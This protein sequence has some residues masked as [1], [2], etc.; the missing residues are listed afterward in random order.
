MANEI[1]AIGV[2]IFAVFVT[3]YF[4]SKNL[5][6]T[7]IKDIKEEAAEKAIMSE[8]LTEIGTDVKD[9]KY[10]ISS[11]KIKVEEL[12]KKVALVEQSTKSAHKRLDEMEVHFNAKQIE[13]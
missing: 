8:K 4:A 13:K 3:A 12:D 9:I 1:I 2:S 11:T 10:D 7:N 5:N 6:K